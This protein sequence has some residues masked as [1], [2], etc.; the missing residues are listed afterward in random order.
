MNLSFILLDQI[1]E[2]RPSK[3][4][5]KVLKNHNAE[6]KRPDICIL[7]GDKDKPFGKTYGKNK[8]GWDRTREHLTGVNTSK[9]FKNPYQ[10]I[11]WAHFN[12]NQDKSVDQS[13]AI[14]SCVNWFQYNLHPSIR[15]KK[16]QRAPRRGSAWRKGEFSLLKKIFQSPD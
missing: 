8:K 16:N 14:N 15:F 4:I 2:E 5:T 13:K 10:F 9:C 6:L 7:C 12:C 3:P 11:F 1:M